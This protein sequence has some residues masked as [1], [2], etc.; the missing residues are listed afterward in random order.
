MYWSAAAP[1][2]I[3]RECGVQIDLMD[4]LIDAGASVDGRTVYQGRFGTH[5]DSAIY[6]GNFR[7]AE[8]LLQRGAPLTL[9]TALCLGRWADVERLAATAT[10]A[11][12]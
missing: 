1:A 12:N 10:L 7:A 9:T 5:S 6:N 2:S 4:V 3:A 11:D 8:H